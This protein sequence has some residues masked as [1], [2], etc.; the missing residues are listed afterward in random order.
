MKVFTGVIGVGAAQ[1][2]VFLPNSTDFSEILKIITQLII[3][4]ATIYA[5]FKK[6]RSKNKYPPVKKL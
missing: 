5:L 4:A 1:V 3:L 2:A 6:K